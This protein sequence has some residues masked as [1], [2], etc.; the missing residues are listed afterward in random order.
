MQ[1]KIPARLG[2]SLAN[3]SMPAFNL[4]TAIAQELVLFRTELQ[5]PFFVIYS[6]SYAQITC[7]LQE[8]RRHYFH[9]FLHAGIELLRAVSN[10]EPFS[11]VISD[12]YDLDAPSLKN[13][14]GLTQIE[15]RH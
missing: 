9:R 15:G 12:F 5:N 13:S 2:I 7:T 11:N 3:Q 14:S 4:D 8:L 10:L 6:S 1:G